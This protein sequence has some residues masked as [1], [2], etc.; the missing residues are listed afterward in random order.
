[1][2]FQQQDSN[3][4]SDPLKK[5]SGVGPADFLVGISEYLGW[6]S[7]LHPGGLFY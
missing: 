3:K 2:A 4:W 6:D 7:G 5:V 1:M